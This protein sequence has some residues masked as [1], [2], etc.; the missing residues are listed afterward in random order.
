MS[1]PEC[2]FMKQFSS[3]N[4]NTTASPLG[5]HTYAIQSHPKPVTIFSTHTS[6]RTASLENK[7]HEEFLKIALAK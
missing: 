6:K 3:Y 7:T 2:I 1:S 5:P 4:Y